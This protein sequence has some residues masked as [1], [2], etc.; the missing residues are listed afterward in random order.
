MNI[1][2]AMRDGMANRLA[3]GMDMAIAEAIHQQLGEEWTVDR[4]SKELLPRLQI[5]RSIGADYE[6]LF[7]DDRPSL[8]IHDPVFSTENGL[9]TRIVAVQSFRR[10]PAP[11]VSSDLG[12]RADHDPVGRS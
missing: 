8:E 3:S 1:L 2:A 7:L 10:F 12:R 11:T 5:R 6:T 9:T 4:I